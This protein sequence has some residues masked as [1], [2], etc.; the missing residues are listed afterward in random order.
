MILSHDLIKISVGREVDW[1]IETTGVAATQTQESDQYSTWDYLTAWPD[2]IP[3]W[4][5]SYTKQ[6]I[7]QDQQ[8]KLQHRQEIDQGIVKP[9]PDNLQQRINRLGNTKG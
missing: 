7:E 1:S 6:R 2:P 8:K 3:R 9:M 5:R 4:F